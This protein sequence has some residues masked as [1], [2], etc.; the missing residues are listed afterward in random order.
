MRSITLLA[1]AILAAACAP[2][3][4]DVEVDWTFAGKPCDAAGVATIRMSMPGESLS[5]D[6]Y[7]CV[8]APFGVSLGSFLVGDYTLTISGYNASG[9]LAYQTTQVLQVRQGSSAFALDVAPV[10]AATGKV[11]LHWSFG[12]RTC[13]QAGIATVHASVDNQVL[14]DAS[15]NSD[16]PCTQAGLD[17]TT[18]DPLVPGMHNF[19]L[20]GV[21]ST[22]QARYTFFGLSVTAIAGQN[23]DAS[24]D[25]APGSPTTASANLTW[26]FAGQ[27]C[28]QANVDLVQIFLDPNP[29]GSGGAAVGTVPCTTNG[30]DGAAVDG[31]T[32]GSHSFAV[33][34]LRAGNMVFRT[35]SPPRTLFRVGLISDLFVPAE[36]P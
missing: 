14:T 13:A 15:N 35:H 1:A 27:S 34:A 8:Q 32:D 24:P 7:T 21:D 17:G 19:D 33:T 3:R 2:A 10:G 23:V 31:L 5:P 20:V 28:A 11:T 6:Q 26:A 12:G 9:V 36:T 29:D 4:Q 18:V 30:V 16:L 25:L 22:G